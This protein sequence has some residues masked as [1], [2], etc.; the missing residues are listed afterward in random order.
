MPWRRVEPMQERAQFVVA[1]ASGYFSI[2]RLCER[3]GISRKT[4][5]K[6]LGRYDG[7]DP[8]TVQDR[9]R[10]P[11][12]CP[13]ALSDE[14]KAKVIETR[15][16]HRFW[17]PRKIVAHLAGDPAATTGPVAVNVHKGRCRHWRRP[18]ATLLCQPAHAAL[19]C[20]DLAAAPRASLSAPVTSSG[21]GW[22]GYSPEK[23]PWHRSATVTAG[24]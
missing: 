13:N 12:T 19:R 3:Y 9:C 1:A 7:L 15:K 6:W 4:A 18:T 17:A 16:A 11:H 2:T 23:H 10:A 20:R 24:L 22:L 8:A 21:P 5:Y 14:I